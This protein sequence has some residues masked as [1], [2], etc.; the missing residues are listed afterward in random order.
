MSR[1]SALDILAFCVGYRLMDPNARRSLRIAVLRELGDAA[2]RTPE[3]ATLEDEDRLIRGE[4]EPASLYDHHVLRRAAREAARP[5]FDEEFWRQQRTD[6]EGAGFTAFEAV[7]VIAAV[8][9]SLGDTPTIGDEGD[10]HG[11]MEQQAA[12]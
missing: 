9:S 10:H 1:D 8:R 3:L 4:R 2:P 7:Q 5:P 12:A 6:L 11:T